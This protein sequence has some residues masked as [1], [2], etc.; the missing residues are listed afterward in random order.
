M[1]E[2]RARSVRSWSMRGAGKSKSGDSSSSSSSLSA[3]GDA[4]EREQ[5]LANACARKHTW[6]F[7]LP[8]VNRFDDLGRLAPLIGA[9]N[10]HDFSWSTSFDADFIGA[11]CY[12]G[13]LPMAERLAPK[14]YALM[15]KLHAERCVLPTADVHVRKSTRKRA[16]EAD[17]RGSRF[18]LTADQRFDE[19]CAAIVAQHGENWFHPPLVAAFREMRARGDGGVHGGRVTIHSF[20][21]WQEQPGGGAPILVAGEVGY[22]VGACYTSLSGF[23]KADSAGTVQMASMVAV[24]AERGVRLWDLGMVLPY[25]ANM[26]AFSEPRL[27]FLKRLHGL[28]DDRQGRSLSQPAYLH[29]L[30]LLNSFAAWQRAAKAQVDGASAAAPAAAPVA[31]PAA[32]PVA[33]AVTTPA[34]ETTPPVVPSAALGLASSSIA[35]AP[36]PALSKS[37]QRK[38]RKEEQ[39]RL[40]KAGRS[41][42]SGSAGASGQP[43]EAEAALA[44]GGQAGGQEG[45]GSPPRVS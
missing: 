24:L 22:R 38:L 4:F 37:Q 30:E 20:E 33:S 40:R 11:L 36:A 21:L 19:V 31:A 2:V 35:L 5:A 9:R 41:S 29:A 1:H 26:G 43:L 45:A 8:F 3:K 16:R 18:L 14:E 34:A 32:A 44:L 12:E 28:R 15:P 6:L 7:N 17:A 25:K 13:F 10:P 27:A 42:N 23:C 39:R